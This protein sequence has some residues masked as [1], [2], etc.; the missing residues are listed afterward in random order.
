[1]AA[2][3]DV[4]FDFVQYFF[5]YGWGKTRVK[6]LSDLLKERYVI[7]ARGFSVH[8]FERFCVEN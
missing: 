4:R 2:L 6:D 7:N 3:A 1:M 8:I 5:F